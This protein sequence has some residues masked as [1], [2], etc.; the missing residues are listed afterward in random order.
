MDRDRPLT[1]AAAHADLAHELEEV[2]HL[3]NDDVDYG[4]HGVRVAGFNDAKAAA[5]QEVAEAQGIWSGPASTR[6]YDRFNLRRDIFTLSQRMLGLQP[7]DQQAA[8]LA[9]AAPV[10]NPSRTGRSPHVTR[11]V[12][13][14]MH[15]AD[16]PEAE[17]S[18]EEPA[19]AA[20]A[21]PVAHIGAAQRI[22]EVIGRRAAE[23]GAAVRS[24]VA[25][26]SRRS[27]RGSS[28]EFTGIS[29]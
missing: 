25:A 9:P 17:S 15:P 5:G 21:E 20:T 22:A 28:P 12:R 11:H 19:A 1:Y 8:Q 3:N 16:E 18:A 29:P 4:F 23:V 14:T 7:T 26:I 27:R 6:R 10:V 2:K 13:I 24:P